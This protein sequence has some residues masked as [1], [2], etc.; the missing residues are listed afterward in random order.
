MEKAKTKFQILNSKIL[1]ALEV[2]GESW[3]WQTSVQLSHKYIVYILFLT[4]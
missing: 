2:C 4:R 3:N 1:N